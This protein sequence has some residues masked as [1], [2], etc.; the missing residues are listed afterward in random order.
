MIF[1]LTIVKIY[2]KLPTGNRKRLF[3]DWLPFVLLH[4]LTLRCQGAFSIIIGCRKG[5]EARTLMDLLLC[6]QK[7]HGYFLVFD[8]NFRHF[9]FKQEVNLSYNF[10]NKILS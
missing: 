1:K 2:C 8:H 9:H 3:N 4:P 6:L 7:C 10:Y 5:F